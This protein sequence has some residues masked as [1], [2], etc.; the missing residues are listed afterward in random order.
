VIPIRRADLADS[1][2]LNALVQGS[3]A[4]DGI[5]RAILDGY[6]I[7]DVQIA[8][9]QIF[10]AELNAHIVGFY[11]LIVA[12]DES[13]LDLLF[14]SDAAQG[15]GVGSALMTHLNAIAASLGIEVVRIVSHPLSLGFYLKIGARLEGVVPPRGRV[16]WERPLLK[17]QVRTA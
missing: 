4:Y 14:V 9:D 3:T 11:S 16:T 15:H 17:L 10:V 8:R 13:E 5:Y 6:R 12:H 1:A 7:S 2:A